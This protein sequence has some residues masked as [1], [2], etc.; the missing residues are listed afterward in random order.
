MA[1]QESVRDQDIS[2]KIQ[3]A[4]Q[5][6]DQLESAVRTGSV[7]ARVLVEFREALDHARHASSAVQRWVE[8]EAKHGDPFSAVRL[9]GDERMRICTRMLGDLARDVESGDVDFGTEGLGDL[10]TAVSTLKE[11]LTR[12][13]K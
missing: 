5:E 9:V 3:A 11:R 8:E 13:G 12:F 10:R 6:L 2:A 1:A 7:D 4:T